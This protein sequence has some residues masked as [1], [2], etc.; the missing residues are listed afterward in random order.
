M[1]DWSKIK[2][3]ARRITKKV[4]A[5]RPANQASAD[6]NFR[7]LTDRIPR[8]TPV[9]LV[10][11][12]KAKQGREISGKQMDALKNGTMKI[13]ARMD[14]HGMRQFDAHR[15]LNHFLEKQIARGARLLLII[16]G[17]GKDLQGVLRTSLPAWLMEGEFK[18][19][20]LTIH[21][22]HHKHGGDGATYVLLRKTD[23]EIMR[24]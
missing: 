18:N 23:S 10:A 13:D 5:A 3:G 9:G 12:P 4:R 17:K 15:E 21:P 20:I 14:L 1:S 16:T 2:Q 11:K 19:Q 22:A 24:W 7:K 8:P 6:D